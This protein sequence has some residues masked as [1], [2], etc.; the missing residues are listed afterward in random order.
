[1]TSR[2]SAIAVRGDLIKIS[3]FTVL[4]V[5]ILG[6]LAAQLSGAGFGDRGDY[7]AEFTDV[8]A[9]RGGDDV[10]IAGVTV[11]K[12]SHV[13][14]RE[15][16]AVVGFSV[17]SDLTLAAGTRARVR[18]KNL[19][20]DR[21]L[22]LLD[23]PGE[24][25]P[26]PRGGTI[27]LARTAPALDLDALLNGF[28][29][30]FA[31]LS[32]DQVN[33]LSGSLITVLQG[34]GG[35]VRELLGTIGS[36]TATVADRDEVIGRVVTN[37]NTVLG[38][39]AERGDQFSDALSKLQQLVSGLSE[40]R[41]AIGD[42]FGRIASLTGSFDELLVRAR[43]PLKDTVTEF[44]RVLAEVDAQRELLSANLSALPEFYA[45]ASRIGTYGAFS[46]TYIC[47]LRLKLTGPDGGPVYTPVIGSN[48]TTDRCEEPR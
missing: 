40:D 36:L 6:L 12:V 26:L 39:V 3:V 7:R 10:E 37:M 22:E 34:Q 45:R 27:P 20:G 21:Y 13:A 42:S 11:G 4:C 25:Q 15:G 23:G 44:G 5:C 8:S 2:R 30:L 17:D 38:R 33:E 47:S 16:I 43:P 29:P 48:V 14:L 28:Q 9:L 31:G 1:M 19:L 18:Y 35:N 46:N 32:P 41:A 24:G